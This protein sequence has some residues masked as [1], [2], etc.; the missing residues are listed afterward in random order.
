MMTNLASLHSEGFAVNFVLQ[1]N[2]LQESV[3]YL[4][5]TI[6]K[7]ITYAQ[8]LPPAKGPMCHHVNFS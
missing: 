8:H 3:L 4:V 6:L 5:L 7:N 2:P 1:Y